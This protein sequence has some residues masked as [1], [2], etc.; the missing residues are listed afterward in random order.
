MEEIENKKN[1][2]DISLI[3]LISHINIINNVNIY[4][5]LKNININNNI[6]IIY[7]FHDYVPFQNTKII[8][9]LDILHL[10]HLFH[11]FS[12]G[13]GIN[14]DPSVF[15]DSVGSLLLTGSIRS[16]VEYGDPFL[17]GESSSTT[18]IMSTR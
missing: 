5:T 16:L 6:T 17:M 12:D 1:I 9:I 2:K 14:L 18:S 3:L 11:Q 10:I 13:F 4:Q 7:P 15:D 8:F